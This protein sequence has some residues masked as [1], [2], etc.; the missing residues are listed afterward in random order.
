MCR[1]K[2]KQQN[3][4]ILNLL[5]IGLGRTASGYG[6]GPVCLLVTSGLVKHFFIPLLEFSSLKSC[7]CHGIETTSSLKEKGK[8]HYM[9]MY[10]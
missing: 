5:I 10:N 2:Y 6:P 1:L 9:N 7:I 3:C 4:T 8:I